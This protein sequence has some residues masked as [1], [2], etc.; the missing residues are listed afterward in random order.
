[1][2]DKAVSL[3]DWKLV[4]T[5]AG[6]AATAWISDSILDSI[7][8]H[9][10][11]FI[12]QI[13]YPGYNEIM[14]R[15]LFASFLIIFG[16]Y[17]RL[18]IIRRRHAE[19]ALKLSE[20]KYRMLVENIKEG[21]FI[22]QDAKVQYVNAWFTKIT[23]YNVEEVIGRDFREFIAPE[24][25]EMVKDRH[26]RRLAGENI[27]GEYEF[28][29][30]GKDGKKILLDMNA[31]VIQY[32]GRDATVGVIRDITTR[33]QEEEALQEAII[34]AHEEKNKS[35][36]FISA[37]GDG[38][39]IQDTDY[40]IVYQNQIQKDIYG[41]RKGEYCYKAYEGRDIICED[42]PVELT[43]KDGEIHRSER[44]LPA[45][46]GMNYFELTSSPL[47]DAT[48]KIIAGIKVVRDVTRRRRAEAAIRES[49]EKYR[50]LFETMAQG[51]VYQDADGRIIS[52]NPA[53][54]KILG[55]TFDQMQGRT[56]MDPRWKAIHEDGSDF[57]GG[58]HPSMVAL[59]SGEEVR[60]AVMGIFNPKSGD[61]CW[62]NV[63]AVPQFRPGENRP[64]QVYTTF[65]D[66]TER[67]K[68]EEKLRDGESF[69]ESIFASIQDG[70]GIIDRDMKII[71]VNQ[72]AEKW[73]QHAMPLIGRTCY[74]AYHGRS[75]PCE[76]CPALRTLKTGES[77]YNVVP[78]H[79]PGG[80]EVGWAEIY[81][82][83]MIDTTT[84]EM[85]GV[86]EYVRDITGRKQVEKEKDR[87][88]KAIDNSTEGITIADEK[89]HFIYVNVAYARIFGYPQEELIG[90]TWRKITPLELIAPTE[91]GLSQTMHNR[92]IG[93][94][95]GEV[96]GLRK[97]RTIIPTEIQGTALWDEK[98]NYQGHICIVR[99]ITERKRAEEALQKSNR[100]QNAILNNIP[101]IA[102][103]K[104][105][106]YK[107]IA[108]NKPFAEAC[109]VSPEDLVGKTDFDIWPHELAERYRADDREVMATGIR[110]Q[111]EE[112]MIDKDER[113]TWIETIKTPIYNDSGEVIGTTGIARD[114]TERKRLEET[115][116]LFSEA[117]ENAP[118]GVQI[119]DLNGRIIYSNRAVKE[120]YGFAPSEFKG[121]HV[122][123]MNVDP[124]FAS[125]VI[126]PNINEI[127][128]WTG[129]LMAKHKNGTSIPIWLNASIVKNKKGE[130]IAL[131]GIIRDMKER[132]L[133]EEKLQESEKK[134][135]TLIENIHDGV[136]IIQDGRIQFGN[137]AL[138]GMIGYTMEEVI[139]K[140]FME[141]VA[142]EDL[143]MVADRYQRRQA[144]EVIP[145][146]YNFSAL[147]KDG[148]TRVAVNMKVEIINY[149]GRVAS[150]GT[151]M[152][153]TER[154]R[155]EEAIKRYT[156]EL[157]ESNRVK[158][159]FID[160]MHHDILNPLNVAGGYVQILKEKEK[161]KQKKAYFGAIERSLARA[162]ELID[163][164]TMFSKLESS[165]S[166]ELGELDLKEVMERVIENLNPLAEKSGMIIENNIT[167]SM[168]ACA[169]RII[170]EVFANL[171]ANA[172][173]YASCGKR[174][175]I[176]GEDKD[177][178][179]NIRA[180]D[181]GDG[182][183]EADKRNIFQRF[184]R[185]E[186]KGVKGSGLGLAITRRIV[187]LH[188]GRIWVEDNPEGGAVF[189]V[190]IP[191][192]S[193]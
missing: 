29:I 47:R 149:R 89:D 100:L 14:V 44:C 38:I 19:D 189:V 150:M 34:K 4:W 109:G 102:W 135:R 9:E 3:N 185:M 27:P 164:A 6:L 148:K 188:K 184:Q 137:D 143:A 144:G 136:F 94:F 169:N 183:K 71:R 85:R 176:S 1:M 16:A 161:Q 171:I 127:G 91:K 113:K 190:E 175:L 139:G 157:E 168:P 72:T 33:R 2:R 160:I 83:P 182:I 112:P 191:K 181:F 107:F 23:G 81:S 42:C 140:D 8:L 179:W 10:G 39:I 110:K 146:D 162:H 90:K 46:G 105:K 163:S 116:R 123:E 132:K 99:D 111:V 73:Y 24:D 155:A 129:E 121:K 101:D 172:I 31:G 177:N 76:A 192:Y 18:S 87:L 84:G 13:L 122:N 45:D 115:L 58:M 88:L 186:K 15:L 41:D 36:A 133:A 32:K 92:D 166:I 86:I 178:F 80:K 57:P 173:K 134:Y 82:F 12:Q 114:I 68:A 49:E 96:P 126:F 37:I 154:K 54:E 131:M 170:E 77:A 25:M 60:D 56:S 117:V 21:F 108:V 193:E 75:K 69:L 98:G 35:D 103:L 104:D 5:G 50:T 70:I 62:I 30:L 95:N 66:I 180:I 153:I 7:I 158:E 78:K 174:L 120:I 147:H 51:V 159:L 52:A 187:E 165:E 26:F 142:P 97:D 67:K 59:R 55:L 63:H 11:T 106:E 145:K 124:E 65:S 138:A 130:P 128:H 167:Q 61:Y 17:S 152:D 43:F 79:G 74:E 141:L 64:Y 20:E 22:I 151:L 53:A 28:S 156:G 125:K 118:D 119:T 40:K 93:I 48:G